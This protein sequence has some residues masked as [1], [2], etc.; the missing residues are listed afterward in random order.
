MAR[1][2]RG[3]DGGE[4]EVLTSGPYLARR[5]AQYTHLVAVAL[6]DETFERLQIARRAFIRR[7]RMR[8]RSAKVLGISTAARLCLQGYLCGE[9]ILPLLASAGGAR[10]R[11]ALR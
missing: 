11:R 1:F 8:P 10:F 7:D 9:S 5:R 6:D 4:E 2:A 3:W